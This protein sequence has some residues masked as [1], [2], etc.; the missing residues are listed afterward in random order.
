M[1]IIYSLPG[2]EGVYWSKDELKQTED[3]K[4]EIVKHT[5]QLVAYLRIGQ[6]EFTLYK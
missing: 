5:R 6:S 4:M 3:L 2:T 1:E